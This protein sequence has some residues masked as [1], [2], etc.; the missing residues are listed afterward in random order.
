MA[1]TGTADSHIAIFLPGFGGGGAE[2]VALNLA[3]FLA[4]KCPRVD[5]IVGRARGPYQ[6]QVPAGVREIDLE[7]H[8]LLA[9]LPR[10][11]RVLRRERP[12]VLF[13][14]MEHT[15]L[16]ALWA[17]RLS[18]VPV[19]VVI[20]VHNVLSHN[21]GRSPSWRERR[22]PGLARLF[23]RQ[24]DG[25]V[26]VSNGVADDLVTETGLVRSAIRVIYNPVVTSGLLARAEEPLTHPWFAPDAAPVVLGAGRLSPQK[27]FDTL[28]RAFAQV[29]AV[30]PAHLIILGEGELRD[31]LAA[32]AAVLGVSEDVQFPGFVE[33]PYAYM[34][35]AGVFV[36]SSAW[37]GFGIA[38][39]E[40]MAC[41][42]PVVSTDCPAGPAEILEGGEYGR[43]A[44]VGDDSALAQAILA[45][46][47]RPIEPA[48]L[49]ARA[50]DF[51]L[52]KIGAQYLEVLC[53]P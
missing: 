8:R 49:R 27:D 38:L 28:L 9:A 33:N 50:G 42:A 2:R 32:Q 4:G 45:T 30:R 15:N 35:R 36:L 22:M 17:R 18:R 5:L 39:V 1:G 12:D 29:R 41:G 3:G 40:A 21:L 46:L 16:V 51:A 10:L 48:R 13:S 7:A 34:R 25:I 53:P 37:E 47:D 24:A 20:S 11:I 31:S 26:A 14:A 52:D 44:P 23:Y 43:L 19:R 6:S